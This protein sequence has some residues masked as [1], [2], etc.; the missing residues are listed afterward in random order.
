MANLFAS[1]SNQLLPL[2]QPQD[3]ELQGQAAV[4]VLL[5]LGAEPSILYTQRSS[6]LRHHPGE[7]SFPGGM[8]EPGDASLAATAVREMEEEIGLPASAIQLIGRLER[9]QTRAGTLVTPFVASFDSAWP[10]APNPAELDCIFHVP[11]KSFFGEIPQQ[12]DHFE[13][14]GRRYQLPA[15]QYQG[16]RIWGFT[17]AVTARFLR[18]VEQLEAKNLT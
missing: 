15:Y 2:A 8:W 3:T 14:G 7:V 12:L 1:L 10:L 11:L 13:H 17:A 9:G 6:R 18:L 16:Y 4:I 5:S